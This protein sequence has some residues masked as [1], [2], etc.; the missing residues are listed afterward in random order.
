MKNLFL[1]FLLAFSL[2]A[3]SQIKYNPTNI[4]PGL[5]D[6]VK[7]PINKNLLV[8]VRQDTSTIV[9]D[10]IANVEESRDK[11]NV[12]SVNIITFTKGN[13]LLAVLDEFNNPIYRDIF[14]IGPPGG[15][16][17]LDFKK[18]KKGR[19]KI[20]VWLYESEFLYEFNVER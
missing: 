5:A 7:Q 4:L 9:I 14:K 6:I 19:Y 20:A 10:Y 8:S 1:T 11:R 16:I 15:T 18:F 12:Y 17:E 2:N 13:F 3:V